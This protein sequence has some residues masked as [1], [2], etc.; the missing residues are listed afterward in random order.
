MSQRMRRGVKSLMRQR[1]LGFKRGNVAIGLCCGAV[2]IA[3]VGGLLLMKYRGKIMSD[4]DRVQ[5]VWHVEKLEQDGKPA[6]DASM[7]TTVIIQ[8]NKL[9][10][11]YTL[12]RSKEGYGDLVDEF[13]LDESRRP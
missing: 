13:R 12:P 11:R 7:L 6:A 3:L 2:A 1:F 10:F 5:G 9:A 4:F 8:G